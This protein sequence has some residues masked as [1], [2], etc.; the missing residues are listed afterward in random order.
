MMR[1]HY[2]GSVTEA[3]N[4]QT[5]TV[6]GWVHRRRDHGG[7]IFLDMR[8]RDGLLQVVIDPDTPEAFATADSARSEYV[9]KITGRVRNRYAGTENKNMTSGNV[10][11][12]AKEIEIIAKSETPPFPLNDDFTNVSEELRLK[13][14]FLDIRRPE[15]LDRLRFRSKVTTLIRNYLDENGFLDVETPILT[16]A[17]PEGARD[18]LVPSRVSNG[19]F[20]AL[21][22]SP[23]LF[24]QL[25]MVGGIDRYYQIAKCFRDEDLRAD[26]QPEFTQIDIETSFLD[27][28]D[29]MDLMEG[30]TVKLFDELMGIKFDKFERMPYSVAMR[31]Y[32]SDKPDL[33]IPLKLVDVAD[34]M[35]DV[36]FKVFG[37]PAKDPKG[38]IVALRV[39]NAGSLPR[40]QIDE[41]TKFVGI[42]G[43][44]GLAYIKVNELEKGIEGLQSPIVKFIEP[45]VLELLQRVGAENGDIV[46]FGADKAKIVNDAMGALRVKIGHDL[47]LLT[48]EWA[49][50]WVVDFPM[51]EETDDGKWTS[52][53]HPFTKP[54]GTVDEMKNSPETALSIA[55]DM[56]L[57]GTEIGGG[58]L[59]INTLEM[60]KAVFE[61]LGISEEEAEEKFSFL[62]NA[63]KYGAP[64]H[65]GLAFGLDRLIMLMTGASSIRD[66]IA[67]PKT[68]TAEC[69]LTEA[70]AE[71]DSKQLRELGIRVREKEKKVE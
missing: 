59:R 35:Q 37:I 26:R 38:R 24:K 4:E 36:E 45:I 9:L 21:P 27:D 25:L 12:L 44:K 47:N 58:S 69:P 57:N 66:V 28:N 46:F 65:G 30:M 7:V 3:L 8:D 61:A 18:Y 64:P 62:L 55:Y 54:K 31:D 33:R 49:P 43:A 68:K 60:Q 16:R 56:V 63:L 17:T 29:I 20:Y 32:A 15:M 10:E 2:C 50:L 14:R 23:Q 34:L 22:Q 19:E 71:V 41:Y 5:I 13:Y 53:H 11:L 42:Y 40:S 51:F 39:P 70:P 48:K 6:C 1:T 67:F 52:V